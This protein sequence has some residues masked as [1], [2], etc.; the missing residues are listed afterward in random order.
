MMKIYLQL[1]TLAELYKLDNRFIQMGVNG[2]KQKRNCFVNRLKTNRDIISSNKRWVSAI[3]QGIH[4]LDSFF[5]QASFRI[6][7]LIHD[8][9][10]G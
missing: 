9:A 6:I 3:I 1:A 5:K 10:P 8:S 7:T 4:I 2:D